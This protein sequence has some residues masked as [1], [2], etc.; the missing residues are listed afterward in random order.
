[1]KSLITALWERSVSKK[2][3]D[4]VN[5]ESDSEMKFEIGERRARGDGH[6]DLTDNTSL[7]YSGSQEADFG[8]YLARNWRFEMKVDTDT[9]E[10][11]GLTGFMSKLTAKKSSLV[12]PAAEPKKL[13]CKSAR[14]DS[15]AA[16]CYSESPANSV[17][18]DPEKKILCLGDPEGAGEAVE[19]ADRIIAV[20]NAGNLVCVYMLLDNIADD[21]ENG[22]NLINCILL[23]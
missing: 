21:P 15:G 17:H 16:G 5:A 4:S 22:N 6:F 3:V 1:M 10:C 18:F 2:R 11:V 20:V 12:L 9:G 7:I 19:F 14:L 8:V 13:L 23:V